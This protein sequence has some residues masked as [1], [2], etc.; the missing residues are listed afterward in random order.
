MVTGIE[1]LDFLLD[2]IVQLQ[3][4]SIQSANCGD[5][6]SFRI[7]VPAGPA[8]ATPNT[9]YCEEATSIL[10]KTI[11]MHGP[12]C[13]TCHT[14]ASPPDHPARRNAIRT[15]TKSTIQIATPIRSA[16]SCSDYG[17]VP[18]TVPF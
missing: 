12:G 7:W 5:L 3:K 1:A 8:Q 16:F 13:D 6:H 11:S 9:R 10:P 17:I 18:E 14:Y 4:L 2:P 15:T